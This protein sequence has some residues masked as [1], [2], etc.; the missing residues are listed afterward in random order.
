M[1]RRLRVPHP[2]LP[3]VLPARLQYAPHTRRGARANSL[4]EASPYQREA[5]SYR[6][7]QRSRSGNHHPPRSHPPVQPRKHHHPSCP[8][9]LVLG[10]VDWE[11]SSTTATSS[12]SWF[13]GAKLRRMAVHVQ[14]VD[15][16]HLH[17]AMPCF[18]SFVIGYSHPG[19]TR[20]LPG[21]CLLIGS[22]SS[23]CPV[24][25]ASRRGSTHV[26]GR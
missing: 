10:R 1:Q 23:A 21:A 8:S 13:A 15:L 19:C 3:L 5:S 9:P 26:G 12:L 20:C 7:G 11:S 22:H 4:R 18:H 25:R 2:G 16:T 6:E 17:T 24:R 14:Q